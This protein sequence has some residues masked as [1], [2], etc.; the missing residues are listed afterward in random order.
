MACYF[1]F[2]LYLYHLFK[3][4]EWSGNFQCTWVIQ[5]GS[6]H[7]SV[8]DCTE[9]FNSSRDGKSERFLTILSMCQFQNSLTYEWLWGYRTTMKSSAVTV[10]PSVWSI[11]LLKSLLLWMMKPEEGGDEWRRPLSGLDIRSL[12]KMGKNSESSNHFALAGKREQLFITQIAGA[13]NLS[14]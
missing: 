4:H 7:F 2:S 9:C 1:Y 10:F 6:D 11:V 14:T 12:H 8:S 5:T 3:V 13:W